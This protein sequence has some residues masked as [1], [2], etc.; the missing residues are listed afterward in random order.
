M[1]AQP[2]CQTRQTPLAQPQL[3]PARTRTTPPTIHGDNQLGGKSVERREWDDTLAYLQERYIGVRLG[4][5]RD[6]HIHLPTTSACLVEVLPE[7]HTH[8]ARCRARQR[9]ELGLGRDIYNAMRPSTSYTP[10]SSCSTSTSRHGYRFTRPCFESRTKAL[11]NTRRHIMSRQR[12][13][14]TAPSSRAAGVNHRTQPWWR[15]CVLCGVRTRVL[16]F[17]CDGG[18]RIVVLRAC[19]PAIVALPGHQTAVY[20]GIFTSAAPWMHHLSGRHE[21][22]HPLQ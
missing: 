20:L 4:K 10:R 1:W 19:E 2:R 3:A 21:H 16:V 11:G 6:D 13:T 7:E 8:K 18:L 15:L 5:L 14:H 22:G 17:A 12:N 9:L